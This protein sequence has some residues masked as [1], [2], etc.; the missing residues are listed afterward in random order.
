MDD[1][2]GAGWLRFASIVLLFAGIMR[3]IDS[4]WAFRY[5]GTL[6]ENLQGGV[7]G[8]N[9]K[10]YAVV[11]LI[12]GVVLI[13]CGIYVLMHNQF[14]RWVGIGAGVLAIIIGTLWLP[15]YPVWAAVHIALGVLV[16][17]ALSTHGER[18]E[19]PATDRAA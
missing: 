13:L 15:F 7:L 8:T 3:V 18:L 14:F 1:D 17:Y 16:V 19:A 12:V 2:G 10:T 11:Y 4:I 6:P 5:K 9:L